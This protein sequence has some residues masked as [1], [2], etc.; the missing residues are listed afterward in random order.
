MI[1]EP[2]RAHA[3]SAGAF[4]SEGKNLKRESEA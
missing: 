2:G 1:R 3:R 4:T